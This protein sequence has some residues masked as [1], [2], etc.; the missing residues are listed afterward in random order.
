MFK[1]SN[2]T[3]YKKM[4][5]PYLSLARS[6]NCPCRLLNRILTAIDYRLCPFV[7]KRKPLVIHILKR[8]AVLKN[9]ATSFKI[10]YSFAHILIA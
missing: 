7:I 5:M 9:Y 4:I 10:T 2:C 8:F 6:Y 1:Y 3:N